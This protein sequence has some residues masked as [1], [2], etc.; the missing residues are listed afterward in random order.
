MNSA[1]GLGH[2]CSHPNKAT[3]QGTSSRREGNRVPARGISTVWEELE[4]MPWEGWGLHVAPLGKAGKT[5]VE[6]KWE[7]IPEKSRQ[8]RRFRL[9]SRESEWLNQCGGEGRGQRGSSSDRWWK[10]TVKLDWGPPGSIDAADLPSVSTEGTHPW[11]PVL[12]TP[13][14]HLKFLHGSPVPTLTPVFPPRGAGLA[15]PQLFQTQQF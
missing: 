5:E 12:D 6:C 10:H 2:P 11:F 15:S 3:G 4:G 13:Q 8:V 9:C 1:R 7:D 14:L